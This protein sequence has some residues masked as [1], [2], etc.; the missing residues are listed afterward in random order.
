MNRRTVS[1]VVALALLLGSVTVPNSPYAA[2]RH[3][4]RVPVG[5]E[6]PRDLTRETAGDYLRGYEERVLRNALLGTRGFTTDDGD[7]IVA[8]C[9][10][11]AVTRTGENEYR[12]RLRCRGRYVDVHR[13]VQPSPVSYAVTYRLTA[14]GPEELSVDGWPLD[15]RDDLWVRPPE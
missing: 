4:E 10:P 6:F 11:R 2:D 9:G 8:E 12:I 5:P 7:R 1:V 3:T 14:D 15:G 13:V